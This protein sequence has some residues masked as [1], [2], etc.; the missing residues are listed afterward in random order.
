VGESPTEFRQRGRIPA[1][2]PTC[3]LMAWERP[4]SFGEAYPGPA[5]LE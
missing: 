4:S 2:V 1:A 3:F 5:T